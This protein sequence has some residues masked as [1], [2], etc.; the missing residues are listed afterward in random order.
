MERVGRGVRASLSP[1]ANWRAVDVRRPGF[2]HD[3]ACGWASRGAGI[4]E[5]SLSHLLRPGTGRSH[6]RLSSVPIQI[7]RNTTC[8]KAS[9]PGRK[10]FVKQNPSLIKEDTTALL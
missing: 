7:K 8:A 2:R 9:R 6:L 4:G 5:S 3:R 1:T 10:S